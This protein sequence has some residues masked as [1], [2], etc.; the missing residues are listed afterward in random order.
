M[1]IVLINNSNDLSSYY[2]SFDVSWNQNRNN[3]HSMV[4]FNFNTNLIN[5]HIDGDFKY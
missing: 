5:D 2:A 4:N 1:L 3:H